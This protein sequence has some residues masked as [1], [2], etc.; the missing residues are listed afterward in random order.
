MDAPPPQQADAPPPGA[1]LGLDA[2][3]KG[4]GDSFGLVGNK[5][6]RELS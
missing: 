2:E 1:N 4:S 5:G 3:G 6:G